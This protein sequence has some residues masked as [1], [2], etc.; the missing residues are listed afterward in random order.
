MKFKSTNRRS[1]GLTLVEVL[2][3]IAMIAILAAQLISAMGRAKEKS[4]RIA[5][6][7][8]LKQMGFSFRVFANE[9]GDQFPV[10]V[11]TN[12]GGSIEYV[13]TTE[14]FRH[15]RA[16]SNELSTPQV[17]VCPS[18]T[19]IAA[20]NFSVLSNANVSYFVGLDALDTFPQLLLAG[21]RNLMTNGVP[22]GSG[23]LVLTTNVTVGWTAQMHKGV[24]N[25]AL[26]D[27]SVQGMTSSRLS[28]YADLTNRLAIP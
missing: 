13:N 6:T 5:C 10:G 27:G 4:R 7:N 23:L 12:G 18:D 11:S 14:V 3:V 24:G 9:Q 20:P 1:E 21:D 16:M 15:F 22:V 19:R 17:L 26:G 28:N 25:V 2:V 8:N